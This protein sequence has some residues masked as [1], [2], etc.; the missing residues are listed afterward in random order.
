MLCQLETKTRIQWI[1]IHT[2][3]A[4]SRGY[5]AVLFKGQARFSEF[6]MGSS[7]QRCTQGS[8]DNEI[9]GAFMEPFGFL[10]SIVIYVGAIPQIMPFS[11]WR[12]EGLRQSR[13]LHVHF[14]HSSL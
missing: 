6:S 13:M 3:T 8:S 4:N 11:V 1:P 10:P 14:P 2:T 7:G 12:P 9:T 5:P